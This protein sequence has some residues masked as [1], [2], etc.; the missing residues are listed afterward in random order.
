MAK[1]ESAI[2]KDTVFKHNPL[3]IAGIEDAIGEDHLPIGAQ[4]NA[5]AGQ[6]LGGDDDRVKL[7]I[8]NQLV[9]L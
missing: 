7:F 1:F 3:K 4:K 5:R 2:F 6:N 9:R 8:L